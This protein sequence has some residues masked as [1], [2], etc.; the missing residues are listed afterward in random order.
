MIIVI[1]G[2]GGRLGKALARE[3]S[4]DH[5]IIGFNH[6]HIDLNNP[7]NIKDCLEPLEFDLIINCAALTD[8]DH[9]ETH[10]DLAYSINTKA[11][12][13][14][15]DISKRK[16]ARMIHIS[17]DY[18]FDGTSQ[19]PYTE[20][21]MPFPISVYGYT[22]F[23]GEN[24]LL[25]YSDKNL[26]VRTSW[27]FGPD[28]NSFIDGIINKAIW[29]AD[30]SA[31]AD[32]F[33]T[34]AYTLDIAQYLKPLLFDNPIGGIINICNSGSCSWQQFGQYALDVAN[35]IVPIS[36]TGRRVAPQQMSDITAFIAKRPAYTVLSTDKLSEIIGYRPRFWACAVDDYI[37]NYYAD[38]A[39]QTK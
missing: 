30:I 6:S 3:Y 12:E 15:A 16:G 19:I 33:S 17:T 4:Y 24:I 23:C 35:A 8:V 1:I 25:A 26:V 27:V 38:F 7:K 13:I 34:P 9:C 21:N 14:I 31:V 20:N 29:N 11:V 28:R 36:L 32:K 18:V 22:K 39:G 2:S 10:S 5:S 37:S